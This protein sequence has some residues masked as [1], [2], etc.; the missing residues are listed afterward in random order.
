MKYRVKGVYEMTFCV[1]VDRLV[2]AE[3]EVEAMEKVQDEI[4]AGEAHDQSCQWVDSGPEI[5]IEDKEST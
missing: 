2:E 4:S 3:D 1:D 5:H